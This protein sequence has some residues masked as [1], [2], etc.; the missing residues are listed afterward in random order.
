MKSI[1]CGYK[2]TIKKYFKYHHGIWIKYTLSTRE[3]AGKNQQKGTTTRWWIG[4]WTCQH[5]T[6]W[7]LQNKSRQKKGKVPPVYLDSKFPKFPNTHKYPNQ[8]HKKSGVCVKF[9]HPTFGNN[10]TVLGSTSAILDSANDN[11]SFFLTYS[12]KRQAVQG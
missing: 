5:R 1:K 8:A 3:I 10:K 6:L 7:S 9:N 2:I 12:S 11:Q 4:F